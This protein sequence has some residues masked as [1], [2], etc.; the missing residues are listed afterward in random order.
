MKEIKTVIFDKTGTITKGKPEVTDVYSLTKSKEKDM[1]TKAA[2]LEKLSEH[3]IGKSIVEYANLKTYKPVKEFKVT[4]GK[5]IE[6][7]IEKEKIY[8]G[9]LSL[10]EDKKIPTSEVKSHL[11]KL[12][13]KR[14]KQ[15]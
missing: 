5:G 12:E 13:K 11:Q 15:Q 4:R 7:T 10:M 2:S 14:E 8:I 9:N 6:G 3:P 1:V